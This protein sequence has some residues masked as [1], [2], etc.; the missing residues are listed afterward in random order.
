MEKLLDILYRRGL[1]SASDKED[2][3]REVNIEESVSPYRTKVIDKVK[4]MYH[5]KD[6]IKYEGEKYDL[7]TAKDVY[8]K[9]RNSI[10]T[11]YTCDDVYIAINAQYHDY[12]T[13]F[14][15]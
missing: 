6:G 7:T 10:D 12:S 5:Y 2:L 15:K 13:L 8:N 3:M 11:K 4:S 9:Y 1:I 14:H